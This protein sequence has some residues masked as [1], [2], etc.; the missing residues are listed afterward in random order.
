[1]AKVVQAEDEKARYKRRCLNGYLS[2]PKFIAALTDISE[3][4]ITQTDRKEYLREQLLLINQRLPASVY[5]PFVNE[6]TRN[7]AVLHIVA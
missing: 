2:T 1:M 5:I 3:A 7:Y 4:I 6:S